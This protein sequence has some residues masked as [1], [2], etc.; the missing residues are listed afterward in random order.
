MNKIIL[1]E[2]K[3][4]FIINNEIV[5]SDLNVNYSY[6]SYYKAVGLNNFVI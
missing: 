5:N 4:N 1:Q 2:I 3:L 6:I